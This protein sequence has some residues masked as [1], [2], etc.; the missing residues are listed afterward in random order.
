M[1]AESRIRSEEDCETIMQM[2]WNEVNLPFISGCNLN[3]GLSSL[4]QFKK[5]FSVMVLVQQIKIKRKRKNIVLLEVCL[6]KNRLAMVAA[7]LQQY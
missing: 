3:F 4:S 2:F 7:E 6:G 1:L 5:K